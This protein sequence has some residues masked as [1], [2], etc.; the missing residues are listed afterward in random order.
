MA[1]VPHWSTFTPTS[2]SFE[3]TIHS[4]LHKSITR[5]ANDKKCLKCKLTVDLWSTYV[6]L[7]LCS[8]FS[9]KLSVWRQLFAENYETSEDGTWARFKQ[10]PSRLR[11]GTWAPGPLNM[12]E[13]CKQ[14]S[15]LNWHLIIKEVKKK[16]EALEAGCA[17]NFKLTTR[18]QATK[19]GHPTPPCKVV[20][21]DKIANRPHLLLL[22]CCCYINNNLFLTQFVC[23]NVE[24]TDLQCAHKTGSCVSALSLCLQS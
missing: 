20:I 22:C 9:L 10:Y 6:P 19:N 21:G 13:F 7:L 15:M 8:F 5:E 24:L 17:F 4:H 18:K 11:V 12:H 16:S 14:C 2:C 23:L 3:I 1:S